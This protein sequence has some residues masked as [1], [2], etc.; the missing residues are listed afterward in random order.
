MLAKNDR[1]AEQNRRWLSGNGVLALNLMSSP[2]SG[3]T[4]L[5]ERTL[6]ELGTE[7]GVSV[8]E[9]DQETRFDAE[10]I[11]ATGCRV[12][13]VNTG[14]GCHLD[15]GMLGD[16]L[17][18][19]DPPRRSVVFV[20]NV[21]NLVCPALFDLG[22]RFR[23]VIASVTEGADKP[24][25]YPHMFRTADLVV[26][27]KVDLLPH[28][29]FDVEAFAANVRQVRPRARIVE[30]SATTGQGLDR[31]YGWLRDSLADPGDAVSAA[32]PAPRRQPPDRS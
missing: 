6:R 31:W 29:D 9:G 26:L 15:A 11:R 2:G 17:R 22:E 30:V 3:K 16:A 1:L 12:V 21:G 8:V 23:V 28:L 7:V 20:E 14:A 5:L 18:A 27:N 13:Q 24:L 10:R 32:G 25:K 4:T 19:L